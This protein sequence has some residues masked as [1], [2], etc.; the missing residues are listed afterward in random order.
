MDLFYNAA[1]STEV[2]HGHQDHVD[3][4]SPDG[5]AS[6]T[7]TYLFCTDYYQNLYYSTCVPSIIQ[8]N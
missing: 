3:M 7:V 2:W 4:L 1:E 5:N 6:T 8:I